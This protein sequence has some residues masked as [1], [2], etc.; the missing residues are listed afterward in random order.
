MDAN[1]RLFT[2]MVEHQDQNNIQHSIRV[3][4]CTFVRLCG[5]RF[6]IFVST[7]NH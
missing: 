7:T 5:C 4:L 1:T 2:H 6:V 3:T